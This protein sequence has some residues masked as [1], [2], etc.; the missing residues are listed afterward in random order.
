MPQGLSHA[1]SGRDTESDE[2]RQKVHAYMLNVDAV[3]GT[4]RVFEFYL[5][6][7]FDSLSIRRFNREA[8]FEHVHIDIDLRWVAPSSLFDIKSDVNNL[9]R[10]LK[11]SCQ[12]PFH[13]AALSS[14][15]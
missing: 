13:S 12:S 14:S 2:A 1:E 3:V 9:G 10:Y 8:L 4:W 7:W 5:N 11:A 15:S 6:L